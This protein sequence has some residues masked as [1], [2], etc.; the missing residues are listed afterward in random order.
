MRILA[1]ENFPGL[2]VQELRRLGHD[3]CGYAQ[4]CPALEMMLFWHVRK[5]KKGC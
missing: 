5:L 4:P 1:D 3:V 2:S